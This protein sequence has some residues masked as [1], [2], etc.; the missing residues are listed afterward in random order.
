MKKESIMLSELTIEE[1]DGY[2]TVYLKEST[3]LHLETGKPVLPVVTKT[4]VFPLGTSIRDV[5]VTFS[6]VETRVLPKKIQPAPKP[7]PLIPGISISEK[8]MDKNVYASSEPYPKERYIVR[9][10]VGLKDG[11]H[12]IYLNIRCHPVQ[13]LPATDTLHFA[14]NIDLEIR[15]QPPETPVVLPDE[16]DLLIIAPEVFSTNLQPLIEHKNNIGIR[17]VF[18]TLENIYPVYDGRDKP[19]DIKLFI[20]DALEDWGIKYVLLVGGRK[21]QTFDWYLPERKTNNDDGWESG[22]ASDL[23]FG[24]IWKVEGDEIVFEDW[25]SNGNGIIAEWTKKVGGKDI[26]DFYPDVHVGRIPC[27]YESELDIAVDKII[28]YETPRTGGFAWFKHAI[29]VA[30]DTFP[31]N[32]YYYEGEIETG[33]AGSMLEDIGFSIEKL[34]TSLSTFTG[35]PDVI[36]AINGG[37]GFVYFAG[38]GNPSVW[39]NHPPRDEE[40]WITGLALRDMPKLRNGYRLPFILVGGCHN[41][42]FNVTMA[43]IIKDIFKYGILGYFFRSP[44]RFYYMEWV[45]RDW[46]SWLLMEKGGG[47]I[48]TIGMSSLGFGYVDEHCTAALGGWLDPRFFDAYVNQSIEILGEVH[49]QAITDYINIIGM[50]NKD[51]IHRKTID[52]WVLIGDPSLKLGGYKE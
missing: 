19:E 51:Q 52:A 26:I 31:S 33:L 7:V 40:T 48:G 4:F 23:Y 50:V 9:K 6:N 21:G 17:T 22:Y 30:G 8:T 36:N 11:R 25:D 32:T 24:D 47:S 16:Y 39:S 37:A 2:L 46:S 27:R 29:L 3:S 5:E 38:H 18:E 1:S 43:N 34:W 41:A 28:H 35:P 14:K 15:Y 13:Y 12:V 20:K 44:Y 10:G 49:D 42:Q 45:P